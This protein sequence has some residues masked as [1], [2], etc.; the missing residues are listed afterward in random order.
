[1]RWKWWAANVLAVAVTVALG[2]WTF[3]RIVVPLRAV[4]T[5]VKAIAAGD[6]EQAVP[7]TQETDETGSLARSVEV[8]KRSA[9]A[10]AEHRWVSANAA[11]LVSGLPG[12]TTLADFG[13][14]LLSELVPIVGGGVAGFY[15]FDEDTALLRRVA[16]FGL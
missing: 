13:R 2:F 16:A 6:Y 7:F 4:E 10:M 8:L 11:K 9:E 3:R 1:A 12:A 14:R 15:V 5:S